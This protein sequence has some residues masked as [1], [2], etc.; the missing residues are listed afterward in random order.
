MHGAHAPLRQNGVVPEHIAPFIHCPM[1]LHVRGALLLQ[2]LVFGTHEPVQAPMLHTLG[3]AAPLLAQ[4]PLVS[5]SCGCVL[6]QRIAPGMHSHA[7][8]P[9]HAPVQTEPLDTHCALVLQLCG[10][11]PLQRDVPGV[12]SP[13]HEPLVQRYG[14]AVPLA[15]LPLL[16]HV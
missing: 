13:P 14:H 6:L 2:S 16:L 10:W 4:R 8:V 12:H 7:L 1:A 9:T 15:Q 11:L 5:Q 3:Q